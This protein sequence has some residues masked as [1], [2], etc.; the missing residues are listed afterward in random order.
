MTK[1]PFQHIITLDLP[2]PPSVNRAF[3]A[4]RGSHLT[5]K[6]AGYRFWLREVKET[7]GRG[8]N[9]PRLGDRPYGLW[10]DLSPEVRG[11][12][13]NRIKL[14]S[15]SLKCPDKPV[16]HGLGIV[17]DDKKMRGLHVELCEGIARDRCRV[18]VV[19]MSIWPG[20]VCM[21]VET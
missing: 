5:M 1:R 19:D 9:L 2:L 17:V 15:D 6:T 8:D 20:Y 16:Q 4:R 11:D 18:T 21:R 13:D 3:A 14:L 7:H 10:I 12:I